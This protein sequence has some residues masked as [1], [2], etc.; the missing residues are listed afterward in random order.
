MWPTKSE[1]ETFSAEQ[2]TRPETVESA[3]APEASGAVDGTHGAPMA[4]GWKHWAMMLLCCLPMI[5]FV[6]LLIAGIVR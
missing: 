1:R 6:I 2:R 3:L 4:P 5:A